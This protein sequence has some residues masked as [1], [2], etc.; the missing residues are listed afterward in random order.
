MSNR[1]RFA[2]P[3]TV[4]AASLLAGFGPARADES[5]DEVKRL[6]TPDSTAS[7]GAGYVFENNSQWGKFTGMTR[8]APYGLVDFHL[9]NRDDATGLWLRVDAWNLGL[10]DREVRLEQSRQGDWGYFLDFNQIP[11]NQPLTITTRTSGIGTTVQNPAGLPA[12]VPF[13]LN[14]T[15]DRYTAGFEKILGKGFDFSARFRTEYKQ[16][17]RRWGNQG[18][19]FLAE[20]IDWTTNQLDIVFG[21]TGEKLQLRAG[22]YGTSFSNTNAAVYV[23]TVANANAISLPPDNKSQ[24]GYLSGGYNFTPTTRGNFKVAYTSYTQDEGF[25]A[26]TNTPAITR[27][28]TL[29]AI[30]RTSLDGKVDTTTAEAG[31]VS[32][33]LP[34]LTLR[35]D[36]RYEDREDKTPKL[37]YVNESPA[38]CVVNNNCSRDGFNVPMSRKTSIARGEAQYQLPMG[39]QVVAGIDYDKRD[40]DS[41]PAFRQVSWRQS[42]DEWAYRLE[43]GRSLSE[44]LNGRLSYIHSD[45]NGSTYLP[46]NNNAGADAIDPIHWGDRNRDKWRLRLD[47]VPLE[48]LSV[49]FTSD[50]ATD[51]YDGRPLGP[52]KGQ[53]QFYGL[54]ATYSV[55][56]NWQLVGWLSQGKNGLDQGTIG[57]AATGAPPAGTLTANQTWYA[58]LDNVTNAVGLGIKGKPMAKL[59]IGA[60]A[61]YQYDKSDY[62]VSATSGSLPEIKTTHTT[63]TLY[64]KY[65]VNANSGVKLQYVYD[66]WSTNDWAWQVNPFA[67]FTNST[68]VYFDSP[69]T[70]NFVG[71]SYYYNWQ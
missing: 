41:F 28:G 21:Y 39:F 51:T 66:R 49:Q 37:K 1:Q 16:G 64:G 69:Q 40:Y 20:P 35:A 61:Q 18:I 4:L 22:Y 3:L 56:D 62:G 45:K 12:P 29:N 25:F 7:L 26:P 31:I 63:V 14:T 70:V 24:Q 36:W 52:Q 17:D 27:P 8:S 44:S 58:Q 19:N 13:E 5:A 55:S 2:F 34:K 10:E 67:F 53:Y 59:E 65:A 47:W 32:R 68:Q 57:A 60:D 38:N 11:Y 50:Y 42:T 9:V 43:L 6:V 54:D 46:A 33:P 15:R 23:P 30:G 71:A 48:P